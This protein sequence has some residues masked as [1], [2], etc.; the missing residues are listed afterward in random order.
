[1]LWDVPAKLAALGFSNP[2]IPGVLT[3]PFAIIKP[4]ATSLTSLAIFSSLFF[5]G[6]ML[7]V[8]RMLSRCEMSLA[9]RL[10]VLLLFAANPLMA[11]YGSNGSSDIV[12][13]FFLAVGI[14][15]FIAWYRGNETIYLIGAGSAMSLA[16]LSRYG[17]IA[18]TIVM[19][20]LAAAALWRRDADRDEVE[21]S[22]IAYLA[23][24][25][26]A[27]ALWTFLNFV[28][29]GSPFGWLG[30]PASTQAINSSAGT[31]AAHYSFASVVG[32]TGQVLLVAG[33]LV[34]G[35]FPLLILTALGRRDIFSFWL[36]GL[37]LLMV[38]LVGAQA[39]AAGD[40]GR[41][42]LKNGLPV[43]LMA[44]AGLAWVYY[45]S[46]SLRLISYCVTLALLVLALPLGWHG[47]LSY[48]YQDMEQAFIHALRDPGKNLTGT[49][50]RG[51]YTVGL[52]S[53]LAMADYIKKVIGEQQHQVLTDN[54]QTYAV[55]LLNGRPQVF[56]DRSQRGDGPWKRTLENPYGK[57]R[58][59]L[60]AYKSPSDLI[61]QRYPTAATGGNPSFTPVF[62]T[63]RYVLVAVAF[64]PPQTAASKARAAAASR[65]TGQTQTRVPTV[66]PS[67]PGGESTSTS[68]ATITR[69]TTTTTS[70]SQP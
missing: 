37:L 65:T 51:G 1:V 31:T 14:F 10:P 41:V 4:L 61:R 60:I 22:V 35:A 17:L 9:W 2:P 13:M 16:M 63:A 53:E 59:M 8:D 32:H 67:Q 27:F 44:L 56:V 47:M 30:I 49:S 52:R 48:P 64:P 45:E 20:F 40:V 6:M 36:A 28:I 69:T 11:F 25:V 7:F 66:T 55:I 68:T 50:S 38:I 21:G 43:E 15:C 24:V 46:G 34:I 29:T 12:Y 57:V 19:A 18:V 58:Y 42:V 3:V 23:P 33:P 26:Y 5:G 54:S 62:T 39:V 70:R